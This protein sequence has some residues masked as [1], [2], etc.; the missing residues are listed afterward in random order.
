[1]ISSDF[2]HLIPPHAPSLDTPPRRLDARLPWP[3]E[4]FFM[5]CSQKIKTEHHENH[6]KT[7]GT[8]R[9][10]IGK[11]QENHK[12]FIRKYLFLVVWQCLVNC[13]LII[14]S[15]A[16]INTFESLLILFSVN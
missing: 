2:C 6:K 16:L 10:I 4:L 14:G 7:K 11:S 5:N 12:E 3:H 13:K 1:M 8:N 15:N 9:R